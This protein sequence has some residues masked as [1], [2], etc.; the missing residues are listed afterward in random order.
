MAMIGALVIARVR[1]PVAS[2][3]RDSSCFICRY[4]ASKPFP[5]TVWSHERFYELAHVSAAGDSVQ[6]PVDLLVHCD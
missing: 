4:A 5:K 1:F 2:N 3:S 6:S